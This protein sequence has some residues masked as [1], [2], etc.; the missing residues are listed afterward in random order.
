MLLKLPPELRSKILYKSGLSS[1]EADIIKELI[2][3]VKQWGDLRWDIYE[4]KPLEV[5]FYT[6]L[7]DLKF[8]KKT[9]KNIDEIDLDDALEFIF[10]FHFDV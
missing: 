5:T 9:S 2:K 4:N 6:N 1:A 8:L 10:A 7:I 3:N